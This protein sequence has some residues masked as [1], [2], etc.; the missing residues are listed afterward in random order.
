MLNPFKAED[1]MRNEL[2]DWLKYKYVNSQ[3]SGK[4]PMDDIK[5]N[6]N[7]RIESNPK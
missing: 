7:T 2:Q 3:K 5:R 4:K 6:V 1:K